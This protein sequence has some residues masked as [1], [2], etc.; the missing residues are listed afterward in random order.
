MEDEDGNV[1]EK[2]EER[3]EK[4]DEQK[5]TEGEREGSG[6]KTVGAGVSGHAQFPLRGASE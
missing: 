6:I 5:E 3:A 1:G 4:E 2:K